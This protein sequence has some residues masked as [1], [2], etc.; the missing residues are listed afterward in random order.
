MLTRRLTR[1]L[2]FSYIASLM[3]VGF[4]SSGIT[5]ALG[6]LITN[7]K[8][9]AAIINVAGRQRMLSQ[10]V[11]LLAEDV[12]TG[13]P[14]VQRDLLGAIALMERSQNAL[15]NGG[16]LGIGHALSP[17]ARHF[18]FE[19][20]HPVDPLVRRFIAAARRFAANPRAA[21]G[22]AAYRDLQTMTHG[23]VLPELDAAVSLFQNEAVHRLAQLRLGLAIAA[24]T[25]LVVLA[26][27]ALFVFAPLVRRLRHYGRRVQ[28]RHDRAEALLAQSI[29]AQKRL[30]MAEQIGHVGHWRIALP[31][32]AVA[33]SDEIY[34]IH[35]VSPETYTPDV[36]SAVAFYH[37]DDRQHV[38]DAI[39]SAVS[40]VAPFSFQLR[41]VRPSGEIRHV[42]SRGVTTA[43]LHGVASMIFGVFLDVTDQRAIEAAL[44]LANSKLDEIAHLDA[45]TDIPNR[46]RFDDE[47][48]RTWR[49]AARVGDVVSVLLI[50]VDQFKSYNDLYGHP[51]GD[52]CL[53]AVSRAIYTVAR[54]PGDVVARYGG[55][56]FAMLLPSTDLEGAIL[57]AERARSAVQALGIIHARS[58]PGTN[59]V[60]ISIGVASRAAGGPAPVAD[61]D[62]LIAEADAMLYEAKRLGRNRVV[63]KTVIEAGI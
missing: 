2:T 49:L 45:L 34:R 39:E 19:G 30:E 26:L 8:D 3:L 18:Y 11:G 35:G 22:Q 60:T 12:Q 51:T 15:M 28:T 54:R 38:T 52:A 40:A 17:A 10:R 44:R 21:E 43:G 59:V 29:I 7:Q 53:K 33:W 55:E 46:R 63:S 16:D 5:F 61:K 48:N 36:Q 23:D 31:D 13:D 14:A 27:E 56:E 25:I 37:P 47:L 6:A 4:L 1:D 9:S 42:E 50:D 24:G 62:H 57:L 58:T 20:T 32:Y 41:I